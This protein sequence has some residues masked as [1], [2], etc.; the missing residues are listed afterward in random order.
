MRNRLV[1]KRLTLTFV[2]RSFKVTA[3]HSASNISETVRD[4]DLVPNDLQYEMAHG[5]SY[6]HITG[7]R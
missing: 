4:S 5:E 2:Q 3:V 6:G 1:P 7:H